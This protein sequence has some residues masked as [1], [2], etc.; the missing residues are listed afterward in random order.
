M[1]TK[2]EIREEIA[3]LEHLQWASWARVRNPEHPLIHVPYPDLTE[4]QKDQDRK[5]ADRV[6]WYLHSQGVV[7]KIKCPDCEWSQFGDGESVGMTP[8]FSCNSTGYVFKPLIEE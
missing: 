3:E 6:L 2:E 1:T 7:I 5:Y 4:E 8:C